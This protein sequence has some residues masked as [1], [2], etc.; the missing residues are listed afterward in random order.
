MPEASRCWVCHRSLDEIVA[1]VDSETKEEGEIKRRI[2]Q[3]AYTKSKFAES[4]EL[5]RKT[6]PRDFKDMDFQFI[7]SNSDQFGSIKVIA[8]IL[9]AKKIMIDWLADASSRL[10][11]GG[12]AY[13][14]LNELSS[15]DRSEADSL[16]RSIDQF[17]AKWHRTVGNDGPRNGNA[18]GFDGL[19]LFEG[20][21]YLI[22]EG[23]LYYDIRGQLLSY[24]MTKAGERKPKNKLRMVD[25]NGYPPVPLCSV[26]ETLITGL[27]APDRAFGRPMVSSE[28]MAN[29]KSAESA[30]RSEAVPAPA[31]VA[32]ETPPGVSPKVAEII[33]KLGPATSEAPKTRNLHEHRATED[34]DELVERQ[35]KGK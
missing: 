9:D 20:L 28:V 5:W 19:K 2:N 7:A 22:S 33:N 14:G 4:S 8:E 18:V 6:T 12:D 13:Q 27:R 21:E 15:L 34:W 17:E 29:A 25:A 11:K 31:M 32:A 26:C 1:S 3:V 30:P 16:M 35:S 24:A 23:L 10:R